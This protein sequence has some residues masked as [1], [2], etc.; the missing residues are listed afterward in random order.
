MQNYYYATA[1]AHYVN[2]LN[3]GYISLG[4]TLERAVLFSGA[5]N[6]DAGNVYLTYT[7]IV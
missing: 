3:T 6:F 7:Q 1:S 2:M 5:G 4:G